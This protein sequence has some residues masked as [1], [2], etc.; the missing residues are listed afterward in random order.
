MITVK[1]KQKGQV[2]LPM[3][4]RKELNL[5]EGDLLELAVQKGSIVLQPRELTARSSRKATKKPEGLMSYFG[6]GKG[7]FK[8]PEEAD[9]YIRKERAAWTSKR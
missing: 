9:A 6:A 3:S 4:V 5:Q 2:T 8:S 1:I 7:L